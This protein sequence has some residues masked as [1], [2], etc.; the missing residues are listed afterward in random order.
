MSDTKHPTPSTSAQAADRE[1]ADRITKLSAEQDDRVI[2]RAQADLKKQADLPPAV[3][4]DDKRSVVI[5]L[6]DLTASAYERGRAVG[7]KEGARYASDVWRCGMRKER[8]CRDRDV[9]ASMEAARLSTLAHVAEEQRER[10]EDQAVRSRQ[11]FAMGCL[12]GLGLFA[13]GAWIGSRGHSS[14]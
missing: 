14:K 6:Q 7:Y 13:A 9:A 8:E 4:D 12:V 5:N 11:S 2:A 1:L 10:A 3:D